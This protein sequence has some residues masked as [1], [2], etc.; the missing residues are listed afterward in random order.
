MPKDVCPALT[1]KVPLSALELPRF[2]GHLI[3][4]QRR[5]PDGVAPLWW[6]P[7]HCAKEVSR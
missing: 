6:T 3:I 7:D 1:K 5:C 4:V 2:G